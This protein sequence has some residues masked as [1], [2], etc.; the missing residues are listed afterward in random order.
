MHLQNVSVSTAD[1]DAGP[2]VKVGLQL[3]NPTK[4]S[5]FDLSNLD[6]GIQINGVNIARV[7]ISGIILQ[8]GLI[9][10]PATAKIHFDDASISGQGISKMIVST[11][12][13]ALLGNSSSSNGLVVNLVGPIKL[14]GSPFVEAIT[15]KLSIPLPVETFQ[16]ALLNCATDAFKSEN[17]GG[18]EFDIKSILVN[19][20]SVSV[21]LD[22]HD[23]VTVPL[24]IALPRL[25][26]L[27]SSNNFTVDASFR[28]SVKMGGETVL[29]FETTRPI[30]L[31]FANDRMFFSTQ[32]SLSPTATDQG[33]QA[34]IGYVDSLLHQENVGLT[35]ANVSLMSAI[36]N[37]QS[38][39]F[40]WSTR[41][42]GGVTFPFTIPASL[43]SRSNTT[44]N[45]PLSSSS[46]STGI[47]GGEGGEK[48]IDVQN[49]KFNG[50]T[51]SSLFDLQLGLKNPLPISLDIG[52]LD[53]NIGDGAFD[54]SSG[55]KNVKVL[56]FQRRATGTAAH[57]NDSTSTSS[58]DIQA[59][60]SVH[61]LIQMLSNFGSVVNA[62]VNASPT[63]LDNLVHV[64]FLSSDNRKPISWI[65]NWIKN[66]LPFAA[67]TVNSL[68]LK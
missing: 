47:A 48:I 64:S 35:I 43:F 59:S 49:F 56:G 32:L 5:L 63:D 23:T 9:T 2:L 68:Y 25:L 16:Q 50:L 39:N 18:A 54:L 17:S 51:T 22:G 27:S 29:G 37:T 44:V 12:N 40:G 24:T 33:A 67:K 11:L 13:S 61:A 60:Y 31:Q 7:N 3:E 20:S 10:I 45:A 34:I 41:L 6:A 58:I 55:G 14:E 46:K 66:A 52:S 26:P 8:Q 1:Q 28:A 21:V 57:I 53:V 42:L 36:N 4:L 15:Q 62:V 19:S 30:S 65:N 38:V